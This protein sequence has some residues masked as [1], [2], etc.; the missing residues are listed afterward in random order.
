MHLLYSC[1]LIVQVRCSVDSPVLLLLDNHDSHLSIDVLDY[2]KANGVVV[3][4]F[5]PH[6]SHRLQPL[7]VSIFGP[8]KKYYNSALKGWLTDNAG[9]PVQIYNIPSFVRT[10][11][12]KAMTPE[13]IVSGFRA[14]GIFPHNRNIFTDDLYLPS[15]VTDRPNPLRSDAEARELASASV[16]TATDDK[17]GEQ[18]Q[19]IQQKPLEEQLTD[20]GIRQLLSDVVG[21]S[22]PTLEI[23]RIPMPRGVEVSESQLVISPECV[24]PF[25]TAQ[26]RNTNRRR[27][28]KTR[29]LTDTPVKNEI[30]QQ[31]RK[32]ENDGHKVTKKTCNKKLEYRPTSAV[33]VKPALGSLVELESDPD[34]QKPKYVRQRKINTKKLEYNSTPTSTVSVKPALDSP[35]ELESDPPCLYCNMLY[36]DSRKEFRKWIQCQGR[37]AKWAHVICAGA[38]KKQARFI[39]ELCA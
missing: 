11:Y 22:R 17:V 5:P 7:D 24:R 4:S 20:Q 15:R 36:S 21:D 30:C 27:L 18:V 19:N 2:A 1:L 37:C 10:A 39:C 31:K 25:P 16:S 14:T 35:V 12:P 38:S 34:G 8:F 28:G 32:K 13:N 23:P 3:L 29:I 33:N 9:R 26:P 6:C